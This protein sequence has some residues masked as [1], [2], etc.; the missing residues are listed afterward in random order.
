MTKRKTKAQVFHRPS[1]TLTI[2]GKQYKHGDPVD[3]WPAEMLEKYADYLRPAP[4]K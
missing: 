1:C 4:K 3:D 2:N